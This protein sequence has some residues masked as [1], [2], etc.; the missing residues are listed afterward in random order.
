M[1]AGIIGFEIRYQLRN[2]VFWVS[3]AIFFLLGFGLT[4]SE[5]VSIGTPGSIHENSPYA[6]AVASALL[7]LFYLFVIT[8]FVA[9]AIVRDDSSGFAPIVRAT[10]VTRT[11][12]ILGRFLG[13]L[14][15]AWL[16][17]LSV[18]LG[19]GLGS[20]MPWVDPE[21][22]GPQRLSYYLW[23]FA[24][25]SI[26]NIF[27][28]SALLFALATVMRSMMASYIGAVLLVMGYLVTVSI[29]GQQI[30][31]RQPFALFEPLGN[32]ALREATRY[33]TQAELNGRLVD[34]DGTM[35]INRLLTIGWGLLFLA[36]T[37]WRFTMTE[38]A[39]SRRKLRRLAKASAREER[40]AA[41]QPMLGGEA[42]SAR[43]SS[44]SRLAQFMVRL[45]VEVRQVLTSPGLIVLALF[46]VANT[47][48]TLWLGQ[49]TYGTS[50]YPT[51]SATINSVRGG[52]SAILI[53]IAAFYGGELVWRERDRKLNE[54]LDSTPVP[55]WVI[56][57][58]KII[59]IFIVLLAVNLAAM[60]T[61]LFYQL[62]EGANFVGIPQYVGWFIVPAAIDGLLIA[63]LAVFLQLLSP[64]KYVGWA[65]IFVWFVGTIFLANM[66]YGN[67]LYNYASSPSVPLSDFMGV[68]SFWKGAATLQFYWLCFAVILAVAGHLMWPR[69][70]ELGLMVR[71]RRA[72]RE[73]GAVPLAI[74]GVAALAMAATGAFAYHNISKLNRYE[75]SDDAEAFSAQYER[76]YL[77]YEDLPRPVV[78]EV[79]LDVELFPRER[80]LVAE[81]SYL[82]RND[83]NAPIRDV[84][85][86]SGSR[87]AEYQR[88]DIEGARLVSDDKEFGYRIYRFAQPLAPGQA[89]RLSFASRIWHRGFRAQSPQT[90]VI[91]NGTFINNFGF[92]PIIGMNRQGLL[93]DRTQRRRQGLPAELRPAK[94]EQLAATKANYV[95]ADWVMSD[96]RLTTDAGQVPIAPGN[97]L[98]DVTNGTR[99]TAHFVS[100]API[101]NF[102]SIQSADYR[103]AERLHNGISLSVFYHPAHG[104]NVPKML[105]AM[106]SSLDY[107]RANFGPYQFDHARIIEFPG[108]AS[109]AQAFA[110]TM[111]Y[112]ESIGFVANTNDPEKIDFTT[113]VIAHEI[114]HQ[115]WAHQVIGADMQGGTISSETLAQYSALMVMKKLY[116]EDKIRRF[117]KYELDNYLSRRKGEAV[118][119]LP[120]VRV[121]NQP[122]I[123]YNKGSVVMYLLQERLGEEAVNRAL[124]RFVERFR[125]KGAPYLRS[126]DLVAEFR[127]EARTSEQ[128]QLITDMF[129][130]I[131]IYDL[132]VKEAKVR[133]D[134]EGWLTTL[135]VSAGKFHAD[136]KGAERKAKLAEPI[137][138]G[139]FKARPGIGAFSQGDVIVMRREPVRDGEQTIVVRSRE[140]PAFAGVDPYNYYVDRNSDDN[141]A[142][143][144]DG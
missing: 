18:P 90:D 60:V 107:Y 32:G 119:E 78:T 49:Q 74:A 85:V 16:G 88:L 142:A 59:A 43:D 104:W 73:A 96:I 53:M 42:I 89:A 4:A 144:T 122:Y 57:V 8:A 135:T 62:V 13:G 111:P 108:Y 138:I 24:L 113:Y 120:L 15:I 91:E 87:E 86:R 117:L 132:K 92:A 17:Y 72:R 83:T 14:S 61:G 114:A 58:P 26:P 100:P 140:R 40:A 136:G 101:L 65:L 137:E 28:A 141:V 84:H 46:A 25:F 48:A 99:R 134:G 131:T 76:K 20:M 82:L 63:I 7:T 133:R 23:N 71:L 77:K 70:T 31:Y 130:R 6:I 129:E 93:S 98:S 124:A 47:A 35:L 44:P 36:I 55:S 12:I 126:V 68:G 21:T 33:W 56:T 29:A 94:L 51:L 41:A 128:Q 39:P 112:S 115:Y 106:G 116:G 66:G 54:I 127:K 121:E 9:N 81:G 143:V 52:F 64:N 109:F 5:N 97:R 37:A 67:P 45:R 123:H 11:Q 3:A 102:F 34:L 19:M 27:M 139:L 105:K 103:V 50:D 2:P 1:L 75:T 10:S 38:R 95:N 110:G 125:F 80:R 69:G 30:E 79:K 22:V 118:E